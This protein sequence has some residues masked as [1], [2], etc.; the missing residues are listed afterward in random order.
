MA[1]SARSATFDEKRAWRGPLAAECAKWFARMVEYGLVDSQDCS[2][3]LTESTGDRPSTDHALTLDMPGS[4]TS[5]PC[6]RGVR[7]C[8]RSAG[9]TTARSL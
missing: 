4:V 7:P 9:P 3:V 5:T 1:G 6:V 2:S 8:R